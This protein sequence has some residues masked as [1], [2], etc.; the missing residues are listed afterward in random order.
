MLTINDII[1]VLSDAIAAEEIDPPTFVQ[2]L[3]RFNA[4]IAAAATV[5]KAPAPRLV[6]PRDTG[7]RVAP[8]ESR[9]S[10]S[11]DDVVLVTPYPRDESIKDEDVPVAKPVAGAPVTYTPKPLPV[12]E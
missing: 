6:T 4:A 3:S 9:R 10:A 11:D 5:A 1:T 8:S 2:L 12:E 7:A